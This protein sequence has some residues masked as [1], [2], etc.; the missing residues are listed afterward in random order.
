MNGLD[1]DTTGRIASLMGTIKIE[2]AG[3]QNHRYT[4]DAFRARYRQTFGAEW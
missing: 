2:T 3:T 1:L 4:M